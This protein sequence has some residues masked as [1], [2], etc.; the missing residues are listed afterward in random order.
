MSCAL[1]AGHD[2]LVET[3]ETPTGP[4]IKAVSAATYAASADQPT[5][6]IH[7]CCEPV[8][9]QQVIQATQP[10]VR[11]PVTRQAW[12]RPPRRLGRLRSTAVPKG[13]DPQCSACRP[14]GAV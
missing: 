11:Q 8:V 7:E 6:R 5:S 10:Y 13:G 3:D 1:A 14:P 9:V 12:G 4:G 2:G